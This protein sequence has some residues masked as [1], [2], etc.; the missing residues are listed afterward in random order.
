MD[1]IARRMDCRTKAREMIR[2]VS[3]LVFVTG[4]TR[5]AI[6]PPLSTSEQVKNH[7][8]FQPVKQ[9][10]PPKVKHPKWART[11][12]D[13]FVLA[14]LETSHDTNRRSS[15]WVPNRIQCICE[16]QQSDISLRLRKETRNYVVNRVCV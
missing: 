9:A 11:P 5:G 14:R 6:T 7:W 12:V 10:V 1:S 13:Y 4:M 15:H 16:K 8:A 2:A 3:V